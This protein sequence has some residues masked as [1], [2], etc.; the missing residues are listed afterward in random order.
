ML[1]FLEHT[2][3]QA[4]RKGAKQAEAFYAAENRLRTTIEKKQVKISEKKYGAGIG[5]RVAVKKTGGFSTGFS[6]FTNLT[7]KA[8]VDAV[9]QALKVASVKKTDKDFKSFQEYR[10]TSPM[11]K[12]YDK[13]I[14]RTDPEA[15]VNLAKDLIKTASVDKRIT[16]IIGTVSM[17]T[18]KVA[19]TN[20]LGVSGE[21]NTSGYAL[22]AYVVAQETA[23]VAVGWDEYSNCY[24]SEDEAHATFKNAANNALKQLHPKTIKTE[25]M[26][27]LLQP[28]ALTQLL[29]FTLIPEVMANN[30]H[31]QQSP[32]V[33]KL[34]QTVASENISVTD[35]A[36][37]PRALGSKPFDDEGCPTQTTKI[38]ET[39]KLKNFLYNSYTAHKD[40]VKCTGNSTRAVG[41]F[42]RKP[43]YC[44]EPLIG[45]TNLKVSPGVKSAEAS[46]NEVLSEAKNGVMT[47]GLIGAH[48][49]NVASGEFSV[50]L[51]MAFKI[52]KGEIV[53]PIKQAMM[54]GNIQHFIGNVSML[55]DDVTHVGFEHSS[56]VAPT[57]LVRNVTI[58]G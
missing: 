31:K 19:I 24:Y 6:Y 3:K 15:A 29:A 43:R 41:G 1:D 40:N 53:H 58:S 27:L 48:T 9:K 38:I 18:T 22:S 21:F 7:D 12:I 32:F 56:V 2:V 46:L 45:P 13:V 28:Q 50:A 55:A 23:S 51:D 35:D 42:G 10:P 25:K 8:A 14:A 57:I 49:A 26:D 54:G 17:D 36:R 44:V 20:S 5:V 4:E 30:I 34:N 16:A 11:K 39:G 33:G 37:I 52:E 47:K